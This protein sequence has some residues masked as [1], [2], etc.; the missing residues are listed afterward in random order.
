MNLLFVEETCGLMRAL[1][2][3]IEADSQDEDINHDLKKK[4][5]N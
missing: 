3:A 4:P 5:K 1:L 2:A